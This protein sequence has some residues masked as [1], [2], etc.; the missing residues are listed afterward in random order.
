MA[1]KPFGHVTHYFPKV[2]VAVVQLTGGGIK[3]GDSVKIVTPSN[4]FIQTIASI[5]VDH[6]P[7][8]KGK[9][10]DEVAIKVDQPAHENA[11]L[12]KD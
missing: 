7:V 12:F 4:E 10:G 11:Q 8:E 5:Q 2:G 1:D 3:V 6:Q 9:K